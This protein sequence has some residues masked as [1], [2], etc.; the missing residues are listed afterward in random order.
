MFN[1]FKVSMMVPTDDGNKQT[2]KYEKY[3]LLPLYILKEQQALRAT[4]YSSVCSV[5]EISAWH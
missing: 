3:I 2:H 1:D 4:C 5:Y